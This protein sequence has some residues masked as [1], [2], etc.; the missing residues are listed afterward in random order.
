MLG[1]MTSRRCALALLTSLG[2][3]ACTAGSDYGPPSV[4]ELK[5]PNTYLGAPAEGSA[6]D[7]ATWWTGF[8]D[9][10]LVNLVERAVQDNLDIAQAMARVEQARQS[11]RQTRGANL[12]Q[13]ENS[14]R[15]GRAFSSPGPDQWSISQSVDARWTVD[16]FGG[17]KRSAEA[18][19][20]SYESAGF[21][22]ANVQSLLTSEVAL[23]YFELRS[24]RKR[25]T[26]AHSS[27]E[28]QDQN[29]QIAVW[30][31]QAGLVSM[32][33]VEQ[34]RAQR[35]QTAAGIPLLEQAEAQSRFRLAVL[36]GTPPGTIDPLVA[37]PLELPQSPKLVATGIPA[38]LLRRRPDIRVAE[39]ELAAATARIG[40][41]AAQLRP[42]L[43]LTGSVGSS[44]NSIGGLGDL[45]TGGVF[46][47][48]AQVIFDGGQ[49][50]AN[51]RGQEAAAQAAL[52]AYRKAVLGALE[53][54]ENALV[55][56][57]T[58]QRRIAAF[59][60][61]V[62]ASSNAALLARTNY[63]VGL[64]DFRSLLESERSLL[65]AQDGLASAE[66]DQLASVVRLY[67]ALGGGWDLTA[68]S[69][70]TRYE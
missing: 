60:D 52:A 59:Q 65:A 38:D 22:L 18:A 11:L 10:V 37:D 17:G 24:V 29:L 54:V 40:I 68:N 12:P 69:S 46:A 23:T 16:L 14:A 56:H 1:P 9:P 63:R 58:V 64:I 36:L 49:R 48:L 26:I 39:R 8:D 27:L 57:K 19:L 33:D 30:R 5:V 4:S 2:L 42:A 70:S 41:A 20:A 3:A 32:L 13:V 43:S 53:D 66:S 35:A 31:A 50:R 15:K 34:A 28:A 47:N 51:V 44:S 45:I 25:L 6:Q 21:S 67:L 55:A 61:Q 7:I 62:Q